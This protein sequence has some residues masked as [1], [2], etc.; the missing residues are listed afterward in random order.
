MKFISLSVVQSQSKS[1]GK[2]SCLRYYAYR[3]MIAVNMVL[4]R[5][6]G[7]EQRINLGA[8]APEP[9]WLCACIFQMPFSLCITNGLKLS[10]LFQKM[11]S[12]RFPSDFGPYPFSLLT[13]SH[14]F[15]S[16]GNGW[17]TQLAIRPFLGIYYTLSNHAAPQTGMQAEN[18]CLYTYEKIYGKPK[19]KRKFQN[20][21]G[22]DE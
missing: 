17:Q 11:I 15:F 9:P 3:K 22:L 16:S 4:G 6:F 10:V 13:P 8:P 1:W 14:W 19:P 5:F 20:V 21:V 12:S 2:G 7:A 18:N